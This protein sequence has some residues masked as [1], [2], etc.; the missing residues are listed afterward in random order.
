MMFCWIIVPYISLHLDEMWLIVPSSSRNSYSVWKR[1]LLN[2]SILQNVCCFKISPGKFWSLHSH[3][4]WLQVHEGKL[5]VN[6][7]VRSEKFILESPL[8][9]MTPVV[10]INSIIGISCLR[11]WMFLYPNPDIGG[12]LWSVVGLHEQSQ[13]DQELLTVVIVKLWRRS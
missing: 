7:V 10:S 13:F 1:C 4:V 12:G 8:Y 6:G 9:E 5:I 3:M 11:F 2:A